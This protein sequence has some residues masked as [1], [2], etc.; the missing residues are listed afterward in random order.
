MRFLLAAAV[1]LAAVCVW[2]DDVAQVYAPSRAGTLKICEHD[3]AWA[4]STLKGPTK[5]PGMYHAD[6]IVD[7][8]L[9]TAWV[10]GTP[11]PGAG[12][13]LVFEIPTPGYSATTLKDGA[14]TLIIYNG[15]AAS[16][17]L[18]LA[19]N[20]IKD[21]RLDVFAGVDDGMYV[22]YCSKYHLKLYSSRELTLKDTMEP[23]RIPL[24]ID[25]EAAKRLWRATRDGI[26]AK[27][28]SVF[29]G[30]Y[31]LYLFGVL[32]IKSAYRGDKYDDTC[33]SEIG[34]E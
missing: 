29:D 16:K 1:L 5:D 20:R 25:H 30:E 6:K 18:F 27:G 22:E 23:Q 9:K 14:R 8:D 4:T 19:N 12:A 13:Q 34:F 11:G 10:E 7:G 24:R 17:K 15:L 28:G 26:L 33:V 2:A 3:Q 31:G 32:T 21:C